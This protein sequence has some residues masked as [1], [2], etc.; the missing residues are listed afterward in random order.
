MPLYHLQRRLDAAWLLP[1]SYTVSVT[2]DCNAGCQT[3]RIRERRFEQL[4]LEQYRRVVDS[5]DQPA[6]WLT[7]SG[8]EPFLR[9]D[10]ADLCDLL[11]EGLGVTWVTL[12]TNGTLPQRVE[13]VVERLASTW[14]DRHFVVNL[15]I[16][17]IGARND[18]LRGFDGAWD[19]ALQTLK[20]LHR[21]RRR[22]NVT[23]GI[24]TVISTLNVKR[25]PEI[26]DQLL[27][28]EPD[29]YITEVAERRAELDTLHLDITPEPTA[30]HDAIEHLRAR[31]ARRRTSPTGRLVAHL[32]EVYYGDVELVLTGG[33]MPRPCFAGT[34]SCHILP[35]GEVISCAV[36]GESMGRL[37]EVDF[38]FPALWHAS[39]A[40]EARRAI[41]SEGCSCPLANQAYINMALDPI[42]GARLT[43][44]L[45]RSYL[46]GLARR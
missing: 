9:E 44:E 4:D 12:P 21:L 33:S 19:L 45:A 14:P 22:G 13:Q 11:I 1:V 40:R 8:G 31:L 28:L 38:S 39:P 6:T 46:R 30:Y 37:S 17:E 35:D 2:G 42:A 10:L 24:H 36:R 25:F 26:C 18:E 16:D 15:S 5:I 43:L 41:R 34:A 32:R 23:L 20:R 27:D 29:S 7:V 3:C